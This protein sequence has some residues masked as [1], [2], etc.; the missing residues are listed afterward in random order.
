VLPV[1]VSAE[2][3]LPRHIEYIATMAAHVFFV[4]ES[5]LVTGVF[6]QLLVF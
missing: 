3:Q 6:M 1:T 5:G 4:L 2:H